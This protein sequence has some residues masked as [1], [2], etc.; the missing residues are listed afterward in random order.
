MSDSQF[1][2]NV[3]ATKSE[4]QNSWFQETPTK[5]LELIKELNL[6][7][8]SQIID[9][10]GGDSHL[11]DYLMD[12]GFSNISVLDISSVSLDKAK[13]RLKE[14]A[15]KVTFITS[16][17]TTF[18]PEHK[19][20]LWHDRAAFHFLTTP[21][22]VEKYLYIVNDALKVGGNLIIS[23]FSKTG[24]EK[25]SGLPITQY[26]EQDLKSLFGRYFQHTK[27]FEDIHTTPWDSKQ[28]FVYCVFKK[29]K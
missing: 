29:I 14:K 15:S 21:E 28:A 11:A 23:T 6:K 16:D 18:K 12:L 17:V 3:Y 2:N 19:F 5:S 9:I 20:D 13:A 10:G 7:S 4:T 8:D 27:C 1:W 24:P 25:C 22:Q 26:S